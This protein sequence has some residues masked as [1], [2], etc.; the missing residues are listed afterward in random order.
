MSN[1][2]T[3]NG[4]SRQMTLTQMNQALANKISQTVN[5]GSN[6]KSKPVSSNRKPNTATKKPQIH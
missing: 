4:T 1:N 6:N 5:N 2:K 3:T